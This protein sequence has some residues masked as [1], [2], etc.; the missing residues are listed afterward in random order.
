[1]MPS[2]AVGIGLTY[3]ATDAVQGGAVRLLVSVR[4]AR[5]ARL[6][7]T[8]GANVVDV[9]EPT[10][11]ALG[12]PD[13]H[14]VREIRAALGRA[15]ALSVVIGDVQDEGIAFARA[16]EAVVAGAS[17]VKLGLARVRRTTAAAAIAR[18]AV[19][20]A[21]GAPVAL[22]AY[23]DAERASSLAPPVLLDV[24][25]TGGCAGFVTDTFDK[26]GGTPFD[27]L[28]RD[29]IASLMAAGKSRGLFT[30]VAGGLGLGEV[31]LARSTGADLL[32]VRRAVCEDSREGPISGE[33]VRI[34][35][36]ACSPLARPA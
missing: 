29:G 21:D 26:H 7:I 14:V 15:R 20:G 24:A 2:P 25:S 9:K 28:T 1:M 5:E 13:A 11:G 6:A 33:R 4:D 10:R 31:A 18:A 16:R 36:S 22:V 3:P 23:A 34:L 8:N 32:G 12:A 30:G 19:E 27:H 17:I 35:A